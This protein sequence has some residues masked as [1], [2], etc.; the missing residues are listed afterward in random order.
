MEVDPV[1]WA[2]RALELDSN[3]ARIIGGG[4]GTTEEY[5]RALVEELTA[6]HP[7]IPASR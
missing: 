4:A 2:A 1:R 6:L 7:S 3:G 5:T